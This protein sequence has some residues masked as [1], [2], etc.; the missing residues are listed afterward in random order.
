MH[1]GVHLVIFHRMSGNVIL[2]I[3]LAWQHA[4]IYRIH[5]LRKINIKTNT[6]AKLLDKDIEHQYQWVPGIF[7]G[8]LTELF[9]IAVENGDLAI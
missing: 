8:T 5:V 7:D 1:V 9:K 4:P 6:I 3:R 2:E